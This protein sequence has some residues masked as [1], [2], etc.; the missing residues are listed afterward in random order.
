MQAPSTA[1]M[2][3]LPW[4]T[5]PVML[6]SS[7]DPGE[8]TMTPEQCAYKQRYWVFWYEA[9]H[10]YSLPTIALFLVAIILFTLSHWITWLAPQS[11]KRR[12]AWFHLMAFFRI[13][14]YKRLRVLKYHTQSIGALLLLAVGVVFFFGEFSRRR[15]ELDQLTTYQ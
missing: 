2:P 15:K 5:S 13:L 8:C 14:S 12:P 4:L 6:H 3:M 9:D 11:L 10:R 1:K 7:R